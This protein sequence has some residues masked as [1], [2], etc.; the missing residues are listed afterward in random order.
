VVELVDAL[1]SK[2]SRGNPVG[3]R[4]PPPAPILQVRFDKQVRW[5]RKI[6]Q[7]AKVCATD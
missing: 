6:G 7:V 3:V 1:D 4:V 5:A 2:S